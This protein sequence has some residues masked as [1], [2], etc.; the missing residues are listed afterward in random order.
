M[1]L[2]ISTIG[3]KDK[4]WHTGEPW[5]DIPTSYVDSLQADGDELV[6]IVNLFDSSIPYVGSA[7]VQRWYGDTAKTIAFV[8][9]GKAKTAQKKYNL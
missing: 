4:E 3:K 7:R 2:V 6:Y 1:S 5:P 9:E 8:L